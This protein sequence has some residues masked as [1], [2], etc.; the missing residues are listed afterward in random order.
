MIHNESNEDLGQEFFSEGCAARRA[1][2][3][4]PM[5]QCRAAGRGEPEGSGVNVEIRPNVPRRGCDVVQCLDR[6]FFGIR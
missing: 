2:E 1:A 3:V 4:E 6:K 5:A